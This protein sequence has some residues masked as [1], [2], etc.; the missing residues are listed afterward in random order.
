MAGVRGMVVS[1]RAIRL[2][3]GWDTPIRTETSDN[4]PYCF[5]QNDS[6]PRHISR[7]VDLFSICNAVFVASVYH[8]SSTNGSPFYLAYFA[9]PKPSV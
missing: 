8:S 9:G 1:L 4:Q 3:L 6:P 5:D 2:E 7:L